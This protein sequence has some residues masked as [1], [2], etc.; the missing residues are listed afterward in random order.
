MRRYSNL[1]S[2]SA[3]SSISVAPSTAAAAALASAGLP[4]ASTELS[5][6]LALRRCPSLSCLLAS[7]AA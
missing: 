2:T 7:L 6:S 4:P 3:A 5:P 1:L